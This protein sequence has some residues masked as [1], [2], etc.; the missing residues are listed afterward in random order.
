MVL[1]AIAQIVQKQQGLFSES[2]GR[3]LVDRDFSGHFV[4]VDFAN[5]REFALFTAYFFFQES[6]L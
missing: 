4:G 6:V 5:S 3:E 1:P 2:D